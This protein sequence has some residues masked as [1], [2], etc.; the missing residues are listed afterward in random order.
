MLKYLL[1]IPSILL[2]VPIFFIWFVLWQ[3]PGFDTDVDWRKHLLLI[4][5]IFLFVY[6]FWRL[7]GKVR[8]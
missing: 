5:P 4:P 6:H 2:S 3:A 1:L 7:K 8:S